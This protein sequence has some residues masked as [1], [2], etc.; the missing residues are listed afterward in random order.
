[1]ALYYASYLFFYGQNGFMEL[2][3]GK[4]EVGDE[5]YHPAGAYTRPLF[6]STS[7]AFVTGRVTPTSVSHRKCL[8]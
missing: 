7:A 5:R 1:M 8:S 2:M 4:G 6:S 3:G